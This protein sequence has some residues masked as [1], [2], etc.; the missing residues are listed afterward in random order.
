[1]LRERRGQADEAQGVRTPRKG[2]R[3][4]WGWE[5]EEADQRV[6][7]WR[8]TWRGPGGL[9]PP[10]PRP[11]PPEEAGLGERR[12]SPR[13]TALRSGPHPVPAA[14]PA[15]P[16]PWAS[17]SVRRGAASLTGCALGLGLSAGV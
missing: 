1:M 6:G 15:A 10:L 8:E 7:E 11:P 2:V 17:G 4:V 12:N 5:M 3:V 14:P 13:L 9:P 16:G